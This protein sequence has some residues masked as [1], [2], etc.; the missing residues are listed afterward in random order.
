MGLLRIDHLWSGGTIPYEVP[1]PSSNPS[2]AASTQAALADWLAKTELSIVRRTN[3]DNFLRFRLIPPADKC[4]AGGTGNEK[5]GVQKLECSAQDPKAWGVYSHEF[6]HTIGFAHEHQRFDRADHVDVD[7]EA[8]KKDPYDILDTPGEWR[9]FG[10][11]DCVS[12]SHYRKDAFLKPRAGKC[13]NIGTFG[14]ASEGDI[15]SVRAAYNLTPA[16]GLIGPQ[17]AL[18]RKPDGID[19]FARWTSNA[20]HTATWQGGWKG[21]WRVGPG[22]P[23]ASD[24]IQRVGSG[25]SAPTAVSR[26]ADTIDVFLRQ[27]DDSIAATTWTGSTWTPWRRLDGGQGLSTVAAI[28]RDD[29]SHDVLVRGL[30]ARAWHTTMQATADGPS[31]AGWKPIHT[32]LLTSDIALARTG[33]GTLHAV[34]RGVDGVMVAARRPQGGSWSQWRSLPGTTVQL[35]STPVLV[36]RGNTVDLVVID[37]TCRV[38]GT[39]THD[40]G[41]NWK[42]WWTVGDVV[43]HPRAGLAMVARTPKHLDLVT[44]DEQGFVRHARW[45]GTTSS[46]WQ[47]WQPVTN[48]R[49]A[50]ATGLALVSRKPGQLDLFAVG[51][52]GRTW[53]AWWTD[54]AWGGPRPVKAG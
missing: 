47:S 23:S 5:W 18:S 2:W 52:D 19:L 21:W 43:V 3:Q 37:E 34:A 30:D 7:E 36:A 10:T 25:M 11:Y 38:R 8:G 33:S 54:T 9:A 45:D 29:T 13:H 32:Q 51:M 1:Q 50:R 49:V 53:T 4:R 24:V 27:L 28:R 39:A 41:A 17:S 42:G 44:V 31:C 14:G 46:N 40:D 35:G 6:A 26:T 48:F 15:A 12:V 22:Q 20:V 16:A